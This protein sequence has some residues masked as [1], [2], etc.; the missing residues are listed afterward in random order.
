[1]KVPED[2]EDTTPGDGDF[3]T[4]DISYVRGPKNCFAEFARCAE[5]GVRRFSP[6]ADTSKKTP[7]SYLR[8]GDPKTVQ[9]TEFLNQKRFT[10]S[11]ESALDVCIKEKATGVISTREVVM[12][13]KGALFVISYAEFGTD[14]KASPDI[15]SP[16]EWR[17]M[18]FFDKMLSTFSFYK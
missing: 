18:A 5:V 10:L 13:H 15:K 2:W 16:Q 4:S 3:E 6:N 14:G 8:F 17:F 11:G 1:M 12:K 7:E 9:S